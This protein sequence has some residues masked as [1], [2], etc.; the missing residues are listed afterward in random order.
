[1]RRRWREAENQE[2]QGSSWLGTKWANEGGECRCRGIKKKEPERNIP[3]KRTK[4]LKTDQMKVKWQHRES[5]DGRESP[6]ATI[7]S[8]NYPPSERG[9]TADWNSTHPLR[10][11]HL[12][13]WRQ[14]TQY[15]GDLQQLPSGL[16]LPGREETADGDRRGV[17]RPEVILERPIKTVLENLIYSFV[18]FE[19]LECYDEWTSLY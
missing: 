17:T 4:H 1:M 14:E 6:W 12:S 7:G 19:W 5:N 16:W 18:E 8:V 3:Q 10:P 2:E 13:V 15:R 9:W 11:A